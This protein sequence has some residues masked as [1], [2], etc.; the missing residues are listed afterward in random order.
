MYMMVFVQEH[1]MHRCVYMWRDGL[2]A[3][4]AVA[5]A[6]AP[7]AAAVAPVAAAVA[8][9]A[10]CV[11]RQPTRTAGGGLMRVFSAVHYSM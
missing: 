5:A 3:G 4:T 7:V 10:A 11:H 8:P 2:R 6:V 1:H 9:V